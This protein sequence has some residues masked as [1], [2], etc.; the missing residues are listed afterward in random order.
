MTI[1]R[2][3]LGQIHPDDTR[4]L[5]G[6][7]REGGHPVPL[8]AWAGDGQPGWGSRRDPT[9]ANAELD[10][11]LAIL[12]DHLG[13]PA[14]AFD[15]AGRFAAEV[16]AH[17]NPTNDLMV[18]APDLQRF[19]DKPVEFRAD[20]AP[21]RDLIAATIADTGDSPAVAAQGLGLDPEWAEH[22]A[23]GDIAYLE[24]AEVRRV[25]QQLYVNPLDLWPPAEADVIARLWSPS[26]W[27]STQTIDLTAPITEVAPGTTWRPAV[28]PAATL[29]GMDG[30]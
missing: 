18:T 11:A 24:L 22:V 3:Y 25:C 6:V 5:W 20:A 14:A 16:L 29:P 1:D 2:H 8:I 17:A 27:P 9:Q 28:E 19:G 30:L 10:C 12:A 4:T 15:N 26:Q 7:D 21:V 23:S 13:D